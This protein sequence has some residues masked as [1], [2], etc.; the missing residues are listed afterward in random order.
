MHYHCHFHIFASLFSTTHFEAQFAPTKMM[1]SY[2]FHPHKIMKN[3][4]WVSM[5]Q[6]STNIRVD[7]FSS[8]LVPTTY[9]WLYLLIQLFAS[10][11]S[12]AY[13]EAQLTLTR[14]TMEWQE[15]N[16]F[17]H[18]EIWECHVY[19]LYEQRNRFL[20][21]RKK[22]L[23]V[24]H[25]SCKPSNVPIHLQAFQR[26]YLILCTKYEI[27]CLYKCEKIQ[28]HIFLWTGSLYE[29]VPNQIHVSFL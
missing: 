26:A 7:L 23:C 28:I 3:T 27:T 8:W 4:R 10:L 16:G 5:L 1:D 9:R 20:A 2:S 21:S 19:L 14:T 18:G 29:S 25:C 13:F 22:C 11:F 17:R 24:N 6:L 12:I 15:C